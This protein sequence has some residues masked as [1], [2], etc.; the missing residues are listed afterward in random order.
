MGRLARKSGSRRASSAWASWTTSDESMRTRTAVQPMADEALEVVA[1]AG[2]KLIHGGLVAGRGPIQ[3]TTVS[4][5]SGRGAGRAVS[6]I[7]HPLGCAS[8]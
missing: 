3:E 1:G 8:L 7:I 2:Q 4:A 5:E 6:L